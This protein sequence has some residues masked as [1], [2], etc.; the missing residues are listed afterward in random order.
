VVDKGKSVG[1]QRRLFLSVVCAAVAVFASIVIALLLSPLHYPTG[2]RGQE[3]AATL[4]I[5]VVCSPLATGWLVVTLVF[6]EWGAVHG[7]QIALVP[8]ISV[9]LDSL[10]T[11]LAWEFVHRKRSHELVS[12]VPHIYR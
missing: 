10:L 7:G 11:F 1:W 9:L 6:G 8:F 4:I 2:T 5:C 12:D 3:L